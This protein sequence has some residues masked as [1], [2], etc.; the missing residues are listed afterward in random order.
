M[1]WGTWGCL[2]NSRLRQHTGVPWWLIVVYL[3]QL[4]QNIL[5]LKTWQRQTFSLRNLQRLTHHR[6]VHKISK[7]WI[8]RYLLSKQLSAYTAPQPSHSRDATFD[9]DSYPILIDN[10]CTACI[11]NGV[12]DFCDLPCKT[13]SS[14][15]G[16]DKPIGITLQGTLMW[17]FLDD[18]D[19]WHTFQFLNVYYAP[20]APH[21]LF[22][23]QHWSQVAFPNKSQA[24]WYITYHDCVVLHWD[25]D[26]FCRTVQQDT[27]TNMA[28]LHTASGSIYFQVYQ[29]V[30]QTRVPDTIPCCLN[31]NVVSID[32]ES[33][34]YQTLAQPVQTPPEE[35]SS[36]D[37]SQTEGASK[38][39]IFNIQ[40]EQSTTLAA[41]LLKMHYKLG[42]LPFSN[43]K[44][45]A[46]NG[47][48]DCRMANCH[49]PICA[50]C[51]FG[52]A[53]KMP[54][55]SKVPISSLGS[56]LITAPGLCVSVDQ[57]ESPI[58]GLL[59]HMKGMPTKRRYSVATIFVDHYSRQGYVHLQESLTAN[60]TL[61][62]KEAFKRYCES[63]GVKV[64]QYHADNGHFAKN[65]F[66]EDIK[67]QGQTIT[68][69]RVNVHFQNGIAEKRIRDLQDAACTMMLHTSARWPQ[70]MSPHLW[71]YALRM[72]ND[73]RNVSPTRKDGK[74][75][76]QVF[77]GADIK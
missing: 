45:M 9:S 57:L 32:D 59:V 48:L 63:S 55:Q 19:Q 33:P 66:I 8:P 43:L 30:S 74:S 15:S 29:A 18:Q 7:A 5:Q 42:H 47:N 21:H 53:S 22:S 77:S 31:V 50:A 35:E 11:T 2:F 46:T 34:G 25:K 76:V 49:V 69:C 38:N 37:L 1:L 28:W 41:L 20:N 24:G 56:Q 4:P 12:H 71:P 10:C 58:P 73:I 52:K 39:H 68:Y 70:T 36:S 16:I 51:S 75:A 3:S 60:N 14:L 72:S 67:Q 64:R 40:D 65:L 17:N 13:I 61:W 44:I 26:K 54:W 62:A 27:H 6:R 23:P